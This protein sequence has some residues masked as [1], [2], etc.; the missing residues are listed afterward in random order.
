MEVQRRLTLQTVQEVL[1]RLFLRHGYPVSIRSDNGPECIAHSLRQWY[2]Q[3]EVSPLYIEPGSPWENGYVESFNGKLRD[4]WLNGEVFYRL[5]EA[6]IIMEQWRRQY[7]TCRPHSA[8]G[9][10]PP[11]P[12]TWQLTT[13]V[14]YSPGAGQEAWCPPI[15]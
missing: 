15:S 9:Y 12:E 3:L 7:N 8:L 14:A 13:Q 2:G 4:E 1:G 5:Q 11:P 10:Q 6:Q